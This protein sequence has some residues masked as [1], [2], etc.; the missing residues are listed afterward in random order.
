MNAETQMI[1]KP[2]N[3]VVGD[4]RVMSANWG[5]GIGIATGVS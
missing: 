3:K 1:S 4:L 2:E 5:G